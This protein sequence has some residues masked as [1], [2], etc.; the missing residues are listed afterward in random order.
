MITLL[1]AYQSRFSHEQIKRQ[2]NGFNGPCP[3]CG[4]GEKGSGRRSDRFMVW[5]DKGFG[6]NERVGDVCRENNIPGVWNCRQCNAFGDTLDYLMKVE[7]MTFKAACAELGIETKGRYSRRR[8]RDVRPPSRP[9]QSFT[10]RE[11]G[12]TAQNPEKWQEYAAKLH[13]ESREAIHKEPCVLKWLAD[14]G[15][16][17]KAIEH[18]QLGYLPG[19][20]GKPGRIRPRSVLGLAPREYSNGKVSKY[21]FIPRG[22]VIP[23][24]DKTG[25]ILRL[26][27]RRRDV[28]I[29][30]TE[31]SKYIVLEG[32]SSKPMLIEPDCPRQL[33]AY[34]TIEAELDAMLAV[35]SCGYAIGA[36]AAL[37]NMGKPDA[38]QHP[39]LA[40]AAIN[41]IALD[42]DPRKVTR[43]DGSQVVESPGGKGWLW[44]EQ[45]YSN[46]KRWMV[47]MD[48]D[49][50]DAF[51]AGLDIREWIATGLPPSIALPRV[52]PLESMDPSGATI[53]QNSV[54]LQNDSQN[55]TLEPFS[56]GF[57]DVGGGVRQSGA[58]SNNPA[59]AQTAGNRPS[60][61]AEKAIP[62][63]I[64]RL[65]GLWKQ[66]VG[67]AVV[68]KA[69]GGLSINWNR[70]WEQSEPAH[71]ELRCRLHDAVFQDDEVWNWVTKVNRH[72]V[73]TADNLLIL[74]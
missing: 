62:E 49:P 69:D 48:K 3:L 71:Y 26:R 72:T 37:T 5:P 22:I 15:I 46:V 55:G 39:I 27:I 70:A 35:S 25:S 38:E 1:E 63:S 23:L 19:Q 68:K 34:V 17:A 43:P 54:T 57:A 73:V 31:E 60:S 33:A 30:N 36:F 20:D 44:W 61:H 16:D 65:H 45:T 7:G 56:T 6:A 52:S 53:A 47:P 28:D 58:P 24:F 59:S 10:P 41:L 9:G 64:V 66:V 29:L 13:A 12:I 50:G 11:W 42:Y 40:D 51:K 74:F 67:F 2:G 18:F 4:G 21:I 8:R 32:S 14:R